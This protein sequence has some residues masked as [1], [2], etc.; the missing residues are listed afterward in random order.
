[1]FISAGSPQDAKPAVVDGRVVMLPTLAGLV[2]GTPAVPSKDTG[3]LWN[4]LAAAVLA[5]DAFVAA[6]DDPS[7]PRAEVIDIGEYRTSHEI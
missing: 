2:G 5:E 6:E 7:S 1:M 4:A 3:N